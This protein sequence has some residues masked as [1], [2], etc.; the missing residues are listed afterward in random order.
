L[1]K[2]I[3]ILD[4]SVNQ[5]E[6]GVIRN[7]LPSGIEVSSL[8]IDTEESFPCDLIQKDYTHVIHTG[9]ILS[10]N[11][12]APFTNKAVSYIKSLRDNGV[13]QMGICYGHQ[14]LCRALLGKDAVRPSPKGFEV[15]WK[16]VSF[17]AKAIQMLKVRSTE[18]VWQHHFDEVIK[19]PEDSEL[20]AMNSHSEI[21]SY[22]NFNQHLLGTQFH[23]EFDKISGD[24][25]F[26]NDKLFIE[27]QGFEIDEIVMQSPSFDTRKVF[28]EFFL[29]H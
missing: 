21:Q 19:M 3:L 15:G 29:G 1:N 11:E 24:K 22:V 5:E 27:K 7:S 13:W 14:L 4:Y 18:K 6:T 20:L 9:S 12:D 16:E 8:F 26:Q 25:Y 23:P 28:F 2:R 10:V 17:T